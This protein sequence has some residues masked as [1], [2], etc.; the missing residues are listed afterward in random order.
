MENFL[1]RHHHTV[2]CAKGLGSVCARTCE[3]VSKF[4]SERSA[5]EMLLVAGSAGMVCPGSMCSMLAVVTVQPPAPAL[6]LLGAKIRMQEEILSLK[7]SQLEFPFF[8]PYHAVTVRR[9]SCVR[10]AQFAWH[11]WVSCG[12]DQ[13]FHPACTK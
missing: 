6:S 11:G 7:W 4:R 13:C 1:D 2:I 3:F 5:V 10:R 12:S 8:F 9:N